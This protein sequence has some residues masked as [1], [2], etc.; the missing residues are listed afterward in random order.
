MCVTE[1]LQC[2]GCSLNLQTRAGSC[3]LVPAEYWLHLSFSLRNLNLIFGLA[4]EIH[5]CTHRQ[6]YHRVYQLVNFQVSPSNAPL[7]TLSSRCGDHLL[8]VVALYPL[9]FSGYNIIRSKTINNGLYFWQ[10]RSSLHYSQ[11]FAV[12]YISV[13]NVLTVPNLVYIGFSLGQC[14][15]WSDWR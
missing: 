12:T 4:V 9:Y 11:T 13:W 10:L 8:I 5:Q 2:C 7:S 3:C 15:S 14:I 1:P 6:F